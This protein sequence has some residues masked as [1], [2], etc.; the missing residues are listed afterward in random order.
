MYERRK[1]FWRT[2]W[3]LAVVAPAVVFLELKKLF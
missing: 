3:N 2:F 1:A